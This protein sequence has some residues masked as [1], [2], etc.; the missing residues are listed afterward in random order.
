MCN[1]VDT[2]G[3]QEQARVSAKI[4]EEQNRYAMDVLAPYYLDRQK[5]LDGLTEDVTREQLGIQKRASDQATDLYEYSVNTF[6]P[7][8]QAVVAEAM[9]D[10]APEAYQRLAADASA[11]VSRAFTNAT[12]ASARDL[13]SRGISGGAAVAA[14]R[15]TAIEAAVAGGKA[16]NDAFDGAQQRSYARRLDAAGLG[17]NLSGASAA[18][19]GVATGAGTAASGAGNDASRTAGSTIGTGAQWAGIASNNTGNAINAYNGAAQ[20][21]AAA[22]DPLAELAGAALGGWAAGGFKFSDRKLKRGIRRVTPEQAL[23]ETEQLQLSTYR[24]KPGVP[25][26]DAETEHLGPMAQGVRRV[27]GDE[28]APGGRVLD[29]GAMRERQNLALVEIS[30]ELDEAKQTVEALRSGAPLADDELT[31]NGLRIAHIQKLAPQA[32]GIR[33]RAHKVARG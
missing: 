13:R 20:A 15:R 31:D 3:Q 2:S 33:R 24:Y 22:G 10:S 8:E 11:R 29:M 30:E 1:D 18:A 26:E 23:R 5:K 32:R 12:E 14:A 7:V 17:R 27:M 6:R 19:Y 16:Y 28:V 25:G 21:Q 4:A 9:K